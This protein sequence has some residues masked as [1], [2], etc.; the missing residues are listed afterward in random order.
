MK[1]KYISMLGIVIGAMV[2]SGCAKTPESSLV[3]QKGKASMENYKESTSEKTD[4]AAK[5]DAQK[6]D[7]AAQEGELRTRLGAPKHYQNETVDATGRLTVTTDADVEIPAADQA[8]MIEVS[9]HPL[10]QEQ[11]DR[12]TETF[13]GDAEIYDTY[14]LM[15]E[16]KGEIQTKLEELKGYVSQGNLDPYDMGVDEEGNYYYDINRNIEELEAAMAEAPEERTWEEVKP[17]LV[18]DGQEE[19]GSFAGYVS[20]PD[21]TYYN[22]RI[23][24]YA[25]FPFEVNIDRVKDIEDTSA[26]EQWLAYDLLNNGSISDLPSEEEISEEIGISF[27]EAVA[28]AEEKVEQLGFTD[29]KLNAWEKGV[30]YW[31]EADLS[32]TDNVGYARERQTG[33]GYILH[34]TRTLDGVPVTYTSQYGG[35]LESMDSDME[36]W[37]YERL[38][39][40]ISKDGIEK[41]EFL[42]RYDIGEVRTQNLELLPFDEII[43]IYEK[44]MQVSNADVLNYEKERNYHISRIVFGYGRIYEPASDANSGLLVPVWN[45][46]GTFQSSYEEEN[47]QITEYGGSKSKQESCLTINAVDGSIIDLGLGY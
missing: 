3:K 21:G 29:M 15:Q 8:S 25:S 20:M 42:N 44:M 43:Q 11:I 14:S 6:E 40:I 12:I 19:G 32:A 16:T 28:I 27:E 7:A 22:Y 41:V 13:F 26:S 5:G 17:Q 45:F 36:T 10:D 38:D 30:K 46:F 2:F 47:G 37:G 4:D 23:S 24:S 1:K 39:M 35:G 18:S 34:Y 9:Q 33:A 31:E